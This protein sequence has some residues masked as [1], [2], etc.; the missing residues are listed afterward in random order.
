M[1]RFAPRVQYKLPCEFLTVGG[2]YCSTS[3]Q[4]DAGEHSKQTTPFGDRYGDMLPY[5][6]MLPYWGGEREIISESL[7][8]SALFNMAPNCLTESLRWTSPI[9]CGTPHALLYKATQHR[10]SEAVPYHSCLSETPDLLVKCV[11]SIMMWG[12]FSLVC[13]TKY[14]AC[15]RRPYEYVNS[16]T[17]ENRRSG[18][19][20]VTE[21]N[22]HGIQNE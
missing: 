11:F 20:P 6:Y 18:I 2:T 10:H 4:R 13:S 14:C 15:P 17:I 3:M 1:E 16:F 7:L 5:I 8:C 22:A 21:P 19:Y 12:H 9:S